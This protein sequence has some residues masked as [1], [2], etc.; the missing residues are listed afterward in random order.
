M[1]FVIGIQINTVVAR[2][3]PIAI[4]VHQPNVE[5]Q[6]PKQLVNIANRLQHCRQFIHRRLVNH[7]T[8]FDQFCQCLLSAR[9]LFIRIPIVCWILTPIVQSAATSRRTGYFPTST[10]GAAVVLLQ[11]LLVVLLYVRKDAS[12]FTVDDDTNKI[13]FGCRHVLPSNLRVQ[14]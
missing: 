14:D 10:L 5:S 1:E 13:G 4:G 3:N 8:E 9:F 6:E 7:T 11:K 12:I 2:A